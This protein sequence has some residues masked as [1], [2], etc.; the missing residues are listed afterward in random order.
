[1]QKLHFSITINAPKEK[2]WHI[3]LDDATYRQWTLAFGKEGHFEGN[4]E[5]G[6]K[7]LFLGPDPDTGGTSGMVSRVAENKPYEFLSLEHIGI[8]A[9]GVEDTTSQEAREWS[10][11][12]ENYTFTEENGVTEVQVDQDMKEEY[13]EEFSAMWNDGLQRLKKLAEQDAQ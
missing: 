2:V 1:M 8:Y 6:S 5:K 13:A 9:N 7:M 12:F 3:M 4:W 10:P 11:A